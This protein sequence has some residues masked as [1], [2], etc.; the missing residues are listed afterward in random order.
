MSTAKPGP[1]RIVSIAQS[2]ISPMVEL[3]IS[4][5]LKPT[6]R[7]T[8]AVMIAFWIAS[9]APPARARR[10]AEADMRPSAAP[11][12]GRVEE[13][14]HEDQVEP[15]PELVADLAEAGDALE[16]EPHVKPDRGV[17]GR[18]DAADHHVFF[19]CQRGGKQRLDER[20][21]HAPAA[22]V[23]LH[24][25]RVFDRV[26]ISRP[27]AAPLAER[28]EA[29]NVVAVGGDQHRKALRPPPRE[30]LQ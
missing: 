6:P 7:P 4:V 15:A 23:M 9:A 2:A 16:P 13:A 11:R 28:R 14:L 22:H 29:E 25:D 18:I 30:P 10:R 21:S 1:D 5:A 24:V 19:Q 27:G 26:A 8:T 12:T 17:V 20:A 3:M